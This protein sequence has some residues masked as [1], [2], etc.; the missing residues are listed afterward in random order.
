MQYKRIAE[1]NEEALKQLEAAHNRY[2]A[3]VLILLLLLILD[4]YMHIHKVI[5]TYHLMFSHRIVSMQVEHMKEIMEAD[6]NKLRGK[7]STLEAELT[8]K[9]GV[10]AAMA[11]EKEASLRDTRREISTIQESLSSTQ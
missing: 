11:E 3:D 9:D 1:A 10:N 6:V 5:F 7:I 2:K 4:Y 8:E